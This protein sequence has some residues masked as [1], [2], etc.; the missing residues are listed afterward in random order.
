MNNNYF[1]KKNGVLSKDSNEIDN[2]KM[3]D[4]HLC[5]KCHNV[6]P[7][8]CA[9]VADVHKK[10]LANY[11]FITDG[12]QSFDELGESDVFVVEKC[13]NFVPMSD[14]GK[15][16]K[17]LNEYKKLKGQLACGYFDTC[18]PDEAYLLQVELF[19]RGHLKI[20]EANL[21]SEKTLRTI[22][23]RVRK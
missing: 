3:N 12:Y 19:E 11:D 15:S 17:K 14:F 2:N 20:N 23:Q 7:S 18:T 21:P 10:C 1:V 8:M 13:E 6:Q 22:R 5:G 4:C 16:K 9:K